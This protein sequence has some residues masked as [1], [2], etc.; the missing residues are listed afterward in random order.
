VARCARVFLFAPVSTG[1]IR[2]RFPAAGDF[3]DDDVIGS[4]FFGQQ[5]CIA[6]ART[7]VGQIRAGG[8]VGR[9]VIGRIIGPPP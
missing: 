6:L 1:G 9:T 8:S 7:E 3:V 4:N 5:N 2:F